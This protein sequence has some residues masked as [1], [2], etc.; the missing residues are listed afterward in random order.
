MILRVSRSTVS[1][2]SRRAGFTLIEILLA[3]L[4]ATLVLG[5]VYL[6]MSVTFQQ[7]QVMR[8]S[9]E[10]ED[11]S[12]GIFNK[13]TTDLSN[14]IPPLPAKCGGNSAASSGGTAS[15]SASGTTSGSTSMSSSSTPSSGGS[16]P[17][18]SSST[19]SSGSAS[20]G[21]SSSSTPSATDDS[22]VTAANYAFQA[23]VIGDDSQKM[24]II[25]TA[26]VPEA[27][28]RYGDPN[29]Q[30]QEYRCDQREIIYWLDP[31]GGLYRRER[32]WVTATG[33]RDL[34]DTL[35]DPNAPDSVLLAE[36]VVDMTLEFT[37][38]PSG[39]WVSSWDGT[40]A[41]S[42][43]VTPLGPPRAIRVTLTLQL[44]I[45]GGKPLTKQVQQVIVLRS[46]PG[47]YTPPVLTATTD[48]ASDS[49]TDSS[50]SSG[51]SSGTGTTPN[52]GTGTTPNTGTS[53][54]SS[55]NTS[56]KTGTTPS[57][58]SNTSGK[59]GTT[60]ST[61]SNTNTSGKTGTMPSGGT[62]GNTGGTHGGTGTGG[63]GTGTGG[64]GT[65]G[66]GTGGT[67]TG[68]TGTGGTGTGGT[69]TGGTGGTGTGGTGTG[70]TGTGGTGT[71][72]TGTGGTGTGG[73]GTGG[74]GGTT[75]GGK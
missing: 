60:P 14:V 70:G 67:G 21:T 48:G 41:G 62:G 51:S 63:T 11:L 39:N 35:N 38:G 6:L 54:G 58:P 45:T 49:S 32:P 37:D 19:P 29:S 26:R 71:G 74:T 1:A 75:G 18:T 57:T 7:T 55:T 17:T 33:V 9:V 34:S 52:T 10:T 5:A 30:N 28:G 25:F 42:D 36:E 66:T 68:G 12:R 50:S 23:G 3:A 61:P 56:G 46:A 43:G 20:G 69:G 27:F 2:R 64:T 24:L 8:D 59:T 65:G 22:T 44:P 15:G 40:Q 31:N 53:A 72:G 73:T 13:M 16:S 4:L 47:T